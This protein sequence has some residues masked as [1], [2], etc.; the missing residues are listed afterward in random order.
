M[1][2]TIKLRDG[3]F[4][5]KSTKKIVVRAKLKTFCCGEALQRGIWNCRAE[6]LGLGQKMPFLYNFAQ[7]S[8]VDDVILLT[9]HV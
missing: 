3:K 4:C 7:L 9:R 5:S 8:R 1:I 6:G 2:V